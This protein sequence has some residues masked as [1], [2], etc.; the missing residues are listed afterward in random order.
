MPSRKKEWREFVVLVERTKAG[1][2]RM[3]FVPKPPMRSFDGYY[4]QLAI[5][6]YKVAIAC[7]QLCHE[8]D[9]D[10]VA[11]PEAFNNRIDIQASERMSDKL[12]AE[13]VRKAMLRAGLDDVAV[14]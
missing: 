13:L 12:A 2:V 6:I 3:Q 8:V 11:S 14:K 5:A 1:S 4:R 9:L 7:E 10:F